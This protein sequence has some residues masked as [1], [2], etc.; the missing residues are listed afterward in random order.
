MLEEIRVYVMN[1][2]FSQKKKGQKWE[3]EICPSIRKKIEQLK[4]SQR[5]WDVTPS[6]LQKFERGHTQRSE[7]L[8]LSGRP[9]GKLCSIF[10]SD[11]FLVHC[12]KSTQTL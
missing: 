11:L 8:G 4:K 3:L 2:M 6:G 5:Y 1:R 12:K 9:S 10:F 7:S